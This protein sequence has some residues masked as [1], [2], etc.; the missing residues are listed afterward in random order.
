MALMDINHY[1]NTDPWFTHLPPNVQTLLA[2][3]AMLKKYQKGQ[4][5]HAIGDDPIASTSLTIIMYR[6]HSASW[7]GYCCGLTI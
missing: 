3:E 1:L 4:M 6:L 2:D 7:Y 5:I